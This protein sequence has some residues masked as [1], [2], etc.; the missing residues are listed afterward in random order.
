MLDK[1]VS[2]LVGPSVAGAAACFATGD[3][4]TTAAAGG[5][6]ADDIFTIG[7][8][9]KTFVAAATLRLAAAGALGLDEPAA[10]WCDLAPGDVT[11]RMLLD[12]TSGI[13]D[14]VAAPGVIDAHLREPARAW[15]PCELVRL[16]PGRDAEWR[17][18]NTNY[19]LLGLVLEAA[20][21]KSLDAVL[22]ELV[23]A[24]LDLHSTRLPRAPAASFG[25]A[26]GGIESTP[27]E[28][29]RFLGALLRDEF[30]D[31]TELRRT[32]EVTDNV[33]FDRYGAG[34][35]VMSSILR[36]ADSPCGAA[37]GHLGFGANTSVAALAAPDGSR[38]LAVCTGGALDESGWRVLAEGAWPIFCHLE[39][40]P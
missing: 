37:W 30:V 12:H 25:W 5:V 14:Y 26:A 8:V 23:L 3:E 2:D 22:H 24:P 40:A 11:V 10:R 29:C 4:E 20:T 19:V 13:P 34:I 39:P 21:A 16:A 6:E 17:Y 15:D 36:F 9:T 31:T 1:L 18:S 32:V 35:A 28:V 38:C 33:E 27:R 7:S